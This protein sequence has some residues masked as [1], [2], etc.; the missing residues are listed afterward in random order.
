M[1][2]GYSLNQDL[3][4]LVNNPK[5]SDIEIL[6]KDE[7][8]LYA[9]RAILAARSEVLDGLLY[10]GMKESFE[11]Q[12]SLPTINSCGMEIILEYIYVGSI[13]ENSLT[14]DNIVETYY[15]A[16]Y[17]QITS[18]Q[19]LI[20]N[21]FR[22]SLENNYTRNYLPELLSKVA[23][24]M[25]L[26]EDNILLDLF[27]KEIA[28]VSLNDI[29]FGRLSIT[30]LQYLLFYTYEKEIPF[31]TPEYEVFR[32]S[33]ILA[34]KQVSNITYKTLMERLPTLEQIEDSI[35]LENKFIANHQ[36]VSKEL[37]P[38]IKYIDFKRIKRSQF[39]FIEPLKIIPAEIIQQNSEPI[40]TDL[41][42]IRGIPIYRIKES[43]LFWDESACGSNLN[44]SDNGKVVSAS[45]YCNYQRSVRA[46]ILLENKGIY[47]WDVIIEKA[48]TYA[49]VG[50]CAS[51]NFSFQTAAG[52]QPTGWVLG[53]GGYCANS[54]SKYCPSFGD[55]T[56]VTVHLD[57]NKRTCAF[58]VN[59]T[60]Y[61]EVLAWNDLPSKLYPV[62]SLRRS[63]CF[64]IQPYQKN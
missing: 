13:K 24:I 10:N 38:L 37:D 39:D 31:A 6:C 12:I 8:K 34:A 9:C 58:T 35:Q 16:D 57:M 56:K 52:L 17:F 32:Y 20:M 62:V 19:E 11:K 27:V 7:R 14:K 18:L 53:S 50:V 43:D 4:L 45:D 47:E 61:K 49:W 28:S 63:G 40:N 1:V 33:A 29:E 36:K 46:N 44:I 59:G 5:Y 41:I 25:P 22:N 60:K 42:N 2:R 55:G 30:A 54:T 21:N 23:E 48:C 51:E 15:A 26:S 64:R 3:K